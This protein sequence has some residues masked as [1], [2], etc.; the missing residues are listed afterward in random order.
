ME[1]GVEAGNG[2]GRVEKM[3]C[4]IYISAQDGLGSKVLSLREGKTHTLNNF[5]FMQHYIGSL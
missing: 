2:Q 4:P 1:E 5:L 3:R